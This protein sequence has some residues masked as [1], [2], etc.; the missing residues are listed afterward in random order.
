MTEKNN[1]SEINKNISEIKDKIKNS[2]NEDDLTS[3][4]KDSL[5]LN[6]NITI[7]GAVWAKNV[8]LDRNKV[9]NWR[10]DRDF[11]NNLPKRH[12]NDDFN[13]GVRYYRG[14]GIKVWDTLRDFKIKE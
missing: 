4:L 9:T 10:F 7:K 14:R 13:Y 12:S 5:N 11:A 3:D 8:C 2:I 1:W 6:E